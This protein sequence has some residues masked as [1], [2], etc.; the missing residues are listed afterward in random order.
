MKGFVRRL[1]QK[2]TKVIVLGTNWRDFVIDELA[3]PQARV[4]IVP[5]AVA[6]PKDTESF[7]RGKT[8][9][10]L[11]LGQLGARKGVPEL[12]SA[13]GSARLKS[14]A[15]TAVLA[16]DGDVEKFRNDVQEAGLA[17]RVSLPGWVGPLDVERYLRQSDILVL[18]AYAEN[19]PLSMLEGMGYGL[20]PV[21]TPVGAVPDVIRDGENGLL[22]PV[23]DSDALAVALARVIEDE[24]LRQKLGTAA[25]R[26]FEASYDIRHYREKLEAT[27]L[28]AL[29]E[30]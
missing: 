22:V 1:F 21:V 10:L 16:G 30:A 20:C 12:V 23:G 11:F 27:Y 24:E 3:T 26:D 6:G 18:P 2:A 25:R 4:V 13:L 9:S 17:D 19:L 5:N 28:D 29:A 14:L 7:E 8:P 15:W